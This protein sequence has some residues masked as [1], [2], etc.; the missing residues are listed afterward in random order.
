M[1]SAAARS[2]LA[3]TNRFFAR[4]ARLC[5]CNVRPAACVRAPN[6]PPMDDNALGLAWLEVIETLP[7]G[8]EAIS[9]PHPMFLTTR[10]DM[11]AEMSSLFEHAGPAQRRD[12]AGVLKVRSSAQ[13]A[14]DTAS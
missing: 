13:Q 10:S 9:Q 2:M 3:E 8:G 14:G 4:S 6:S 12:M 1:V 7:D 11:C 5:A